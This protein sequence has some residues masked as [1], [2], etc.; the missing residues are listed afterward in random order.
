[1]R[2]SAAPALAGQSSDLRRRRIALLE[3]MLRD[4][5]PNGD[6][7]A[8][9]QRPALQRAATS[10]LDAQ[11]A[12]ERVDPLAS[13][14]QVLGSVS[15]DENHTIP[16]ASRLQRAFGTA[17]LKQARREVALEAER[18]GHGASF[19][20]LAATLDDPGAEPDLSDLALRLGRS[21]SS[22]R[23]ALN[24]LRRRL[25]QRVD[26]GIALWS[27]TPQGRQALRRQLHAVLAHAEPTA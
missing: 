9:C 22:L 19:E 10:W 14:I 25:R 12:A 23:T 1:M 17:L 4:V 16:S 5:V 13:L 2:P 6:D 20:A 8:H 21:E 27:N 3:Q 11:D 15:L 7:A 26:A 24:R 18:A